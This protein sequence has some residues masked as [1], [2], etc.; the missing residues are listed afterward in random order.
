[1]TISAAKILETTA[2]RF[3]KLPFLV[4]VLA[5]AVVFTGCSSSTGTVVTALQPAVGGTLFKNILVIGVANNYE[6]RAQ[7]ERELVSELRAADTTATAMYVAAGDNK[8][9]EQRA[10]E[11]L[12]S[13][14][15]FDAVLI[16][17]VVN[18][19]TAAAMKTGSAATKSVRKGGGIDLFRYDYE[20]IN[21]PVTV[22]VDLSIAFT[23]ELFAASDSQKVW[24]IESSISHKEHLE[25]IINEAADIIVR[26]LK[27]DRLIRH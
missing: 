16:S 2:Y 21:G 5:G 10:I 23:T 9:I 11:E 15:G 8:S 24:A 14:R 1:M 7:F 20:E 22:D 13:A 27:K 4:A 3:S 25:Q 18:R 6:G 17:R 12:V 26:G 19:S